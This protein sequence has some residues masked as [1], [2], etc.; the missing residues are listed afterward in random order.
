[1]LGLHPWFPALELLKPSEVPE[2]YGREECL[3]LFIK[4]ALFHGTWVYTNEVTLGGSLHSLRVGAGCR[5]NQTCDQ[6]LGTLSPIPRL[7][8]LEDPP[9]W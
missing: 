5:W 6:R 4:K 3:L 7:Q 9:Y 2:W 1:M 8:G